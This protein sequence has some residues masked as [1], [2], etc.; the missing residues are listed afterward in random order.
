MTQKD[1]ILKFLEEAAQVPLLF[2]EITVLLSVPK[3]AEEQLREILGELI[4]EGLVVQT[5]KKRYA[6]AVKMGLIKGKFIGNERG[7]GF[8]EQEGEDLYIAANA[9]GNA[10]HGDIVLARPFVKR[11]HFGRCEGEI[12]RV[13]HRSERVLV[14]TFEKNDIG[15]FVVLDDKRFPFD[16]FIPRA[17][18]AGAEND[19]KVVVQIVEYE[20]KMRNPIGKVTEVLGNRLEIGVDILAIIRQ[21]GITE[22]FSKKVQQAAVQASGLTITDEIANRE[23]FREHL[24]FTIDGDDAKDLDDAVE[25]SKC[26]NGNYRLGVHIADVG[27]YVPYGGVLDQEAYRRGTS[28]YLVDRVIPMLPVELSNG[29]CSLHPET[30][31]LTLSVIMEIDLSG[32][33]VDHEIV[34]S[35]ICSKARMTY[36]DVTAILEG[37]TELRTKYE[38]LSDSIFLMKELK[39][40]LYQRRIK[41]GG[42][43]FDFPETKI[44]L[45]EHGKPVD[46]SKYEITESNHII[47]EFM[48]ICNET[49]AEDF[50]YRESP[51]IYRVHEKPSEEKIRDFVKFASAFG[52]H[53][54]HSQDN[55]HPKEFQKLLAKIKNTREERIISTVMLRSLMKARYSSENLGHFGLAAKFYCHF[56]SPIRRYPDLVIHRIIADTICGK[57]IKEDELLQFT[58]TAAE[59]S[60]EREIAA[61]EAERDTNDLKKAEY[62]QSRLGE[63][64]NGVI[65]SVTSFGMFV[66][67]DNTIEGLVRMADLDDDYYIYDEKQHCLIGEHTK[68]TYRIGDEVTVQA[69][70]ADVESRQIDFILPH[71]IGEGYAILRGRKIHEK[72]KNHGHVKQAGKKDHKRYLRKKKKRR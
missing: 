49:I 37:D 31:R 35:V 38:F 62:M 51:F 56:T 7:F 11:K 14:G 55:I 13:L 6:A 40:I 59:H 47:E 20:S 57:N 52:Y 64:F 5:K 60:S 44:V 22:H 4:S 69:V 12:L 1:K 53:I 32:K 45:D 21:H 36:H 29:S 23:D 48:L 42:I 41:R 39:D 15:G 2:D 18:T 26:E 50:F 67:L 17:E 65:S 63:I 3:D 61:M 30:D 10:L 8:V 54:K 72:K 71:E 33:V 24:I 58:E 34:K 9:V 16:I 43:N 68:H 28:V 25:I 70:R 66:E 27:H 19:D 46:I